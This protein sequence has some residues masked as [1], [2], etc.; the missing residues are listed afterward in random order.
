MFISYLSY[1]CLLPNLKQLLLQLRNLNSK[2]FLLLLVLAAQ[3]SKLL[4]ML[5]PVLCVLPEVVLEHVFPLIQFSLQLRN[6][7]FM[8]PSQLLQ[9]L[10]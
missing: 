4:G 3:L 10:L 5:L 8:L 9:L 7:G 2:L 6:L 1:F